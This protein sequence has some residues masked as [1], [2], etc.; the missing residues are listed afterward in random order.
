MNDASSAIAP[1]AGT[2]S[3]FAATSSSAVV[4]AK[5]RFRFGAVA[6]RLVVRERLDARRH[7]ARDVRDHDELVDLRLER[8]QR[9]GELG[10]RAVRDDDRATRRFIAST[11][12]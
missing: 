5:P 12:R 4:R 3:G 9:L 8:G 7:R 6:E 1:R 10:R 2:A 11:S